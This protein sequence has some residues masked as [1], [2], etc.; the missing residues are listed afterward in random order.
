M[1]I[2]PDQREILLKA[3]EPKPGYDGAKIVYPSFLSY[4]IEEV[5]MA[6]YAEAGKNFREACIL[7]LKVVAPE[8]VT[9]AYA[10]A[11]QRWAVAFKNSGAPVETGKE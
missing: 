7:F 1:P 6:A 3:I 4:E 2:A 9:P 8:V 5:I 10:P 11:D